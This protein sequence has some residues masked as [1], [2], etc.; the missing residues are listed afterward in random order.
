MRLVLDTNVLVAATRSRAGASN[1]LVDAALRRRF[2]LL[3]SVPL[4]VEYEAVMTRPEHLAASGLTAAEVRILLDAVAAAAE[5]VLL[6]F[7]WRPLLRD[8]NDDMVL[9]TAIN[10]R[11]DGLVTF[12]AA[13]FVGSDRFG[14][15]IISPVTALRET[16]EIE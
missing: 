13:D 4:F 10:G 9:E 7:L 15:R 3:V 12:N 14:V 5:P 8:A 16:G 6:S 11:A 2:T 1:R